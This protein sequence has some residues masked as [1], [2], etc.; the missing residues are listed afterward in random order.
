MHV[1]FDPKLIGYL[2]LREKALKE[3][4]ARALYQMARIYASMKGKN[5]EEA[6]YWYHK[7]AEQGSEAG[8]HHL[9]QFYKLTEQYKM[10]V[11]WYRKYA[12]FRIKQRREC[13]GW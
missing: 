10:A 6:A 7:S 11:K 2:K 1:A 4:D 5:D 9:A 8:T 13:L 12:A 3:R